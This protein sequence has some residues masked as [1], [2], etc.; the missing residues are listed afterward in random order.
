M[1][2]VNQR[3]QKYSEI[4]SLPMLGPNKYKATALARLYK[5]SQPILYIIV[6]VYGYEE[7][8]NIAAF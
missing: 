3:R 5:R 6:S 2:L 1:H 7:I 8:A 4:V